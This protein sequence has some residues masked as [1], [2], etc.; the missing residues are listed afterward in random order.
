MAGEREG[1]KAEEVKAGVRVEATVEVGTEA[2]MA[3]VREVA[4][5]GEAM[6]EVG[7]EVDSMVEE[8]RVVVERA[9]VVLVAA[10]LAQE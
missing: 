10:G 2:A 4:V 7:M 5:W 9:V 3:E 1:A 8:G 6:V